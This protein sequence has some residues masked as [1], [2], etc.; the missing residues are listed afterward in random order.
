MPASPPP[1]TPPPPPFNR[2]PVL[3]KDVQTPIVLSMTAGRL[4]DYP[5]PEDLFSDPVSSVIPLEKYN[6]IIYNI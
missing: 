2:P 3:K 1:I 5:I 4:Y 6:I